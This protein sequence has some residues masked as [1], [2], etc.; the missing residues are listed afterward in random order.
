M[1][2]NS[3]RKRPTRV[4]LLAWLVLS[5]T[6]WNGLRLISAIVQWDLLREYA[7]LPGPFY[8]AASGAFWFLV[9]L[10]LVW[11]LLRGKSWSRTMVIIAAVC[12]AGWYWFDRL[13][14]QF[15]RPNWPF[16][17]AVSLLLLGFTCFAVFYRRSVTFFRQRES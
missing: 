12:Y 14:L 6:A 11:G 10:P 9:G 4:T 17:L 15:P 7:P 3:S 5:L 1:P 2:P 8:I 16:A 13:T